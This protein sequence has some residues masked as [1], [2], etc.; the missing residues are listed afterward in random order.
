MTIRLL[1]FWL[2]GGASILV[3]R[4]GAAGT[5]PGMY[6]WPRGVN[7]ASVYS[8]KIRQSH[9]RFPYE[10]DA[11]VSARGQFWKQALA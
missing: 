9:R 1:D 8:S 3:W 7:R 2:L 6:P 11:C 5:C 4:L 10:T